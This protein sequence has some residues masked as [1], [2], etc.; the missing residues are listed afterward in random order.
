MHRHLAWR[1]SAGR[2]ALSILIVLTAATG[3]RAQNTFS[4]DFTGTST[5]NSWL[6][7]NGACL[8]AGTATG[9]GTAGSNPGSPPSCVSIAN[10]YYKRDVSALQPRGDLAL[11]GGQN[12]TSGNAQTLP[13]PVGQGALRFT[14]G[15]PYG[16]NENGAIVSSSAFDAGQGVQITFKTVTY[17]G[18]SGG[19]THDGADGIGFYL[20]DATQFPATPTSSPIWNG[21]GGFGGSLGYSCSNTNFPYDGLVAGYIGLGIDEYGNFL[22]AAD[23][24]ATGAASGQ[25][26]QRIGLRG[27]GSISWNWLHANYPGQYPTSQL[28][29]PAPTRPPQV[30]AG[31]TATLAQYAVYKTCS[32]GLLY[33]TTTPVADYSYLPNASA[34][35]PR[36]TLIAGEYAS[37]VYSRPEATP[38]YYNLK[39]TQNGLLSLAYSINGG[40]YNQI[41]T[42]RD[43]TAANAPLPAKLYFGFTG[44]AGAV[45]NIHEILCFKATPADSASTSTTTDQ[46]QTGKVQTG[47]QVYFAFYNPNDWTG[48]MTAY[49]LSVNGSGV[50]SIDPTAVWD[51]QCVLTGVANLPN[52][53]CPTTGL[54]TPAS[55]EPPTTGSGGRVMLTWNGLD[56][57]ANPGSAGIPFEWASI[58]GAE[59]STLDA[60]DAGSPNANRLNY[61][62]GVRTHEV[63]TAGV[64]LFR[65][66]DGI[67][68]DIVD[69]SPVWVGAPSSPYSLA[70]YDRYVSADATPENS[71][72]NSYASFRSNNVSRLN[73]IYVG[74]NDGFLHAFRTGVEDGTGTLLSAPAVNDGQEILAY[75]PGPILDSIRNATTPA[76]DLSDP[77]YAH[78]FSVDAS[79]G[80]GDL[81]YGGAWHTWLVGGLGAGGAGIYALDITDPST[82]SFSESNAAAIVKGDWNSATI[83]CA[84]LG[85]C[86]SHLGNTY[87]TPVIRRLHNGQWAAIFGNGFGS[88]S[89]DAGIYVMTIDQA[90][91]ATTFYYLSTGTGSAASPNGIAYV[92]AADLDGDHITDYVYAG[93]L[94]GNVWRFDL[95]AA[96]PSSWAVRSGA[97]FKTQAGQPITTPLIVATAQLT[98]GAP[99]VLL[100]FGTG[101]RTQITTTTPTTY[102]T[103]TQSL[104]GVWDWDFS[105]WNAHSA[106]IYSSL[107]AAQMAAAAGSA[108]APLTYAKLQAQTFA[109]GATA[110]TVDTSNAT[111]NWAECTTTS[112]ITCGAT[113]FG[114]YVNLPG[115]SGTGSAEQ[116]VSNPILYQQALI[117]NSVIP[118]SNS[119]LSCSSSTDQGI[120][121]VISVTSGGTFTTST[122]TRTSGFLNHTDTA[123]VGLLTNQTGALTILST[124]SGSTYAIGQNLT[125]TSGTSGA[126]PAPPGSAIGLNLPTNT[127]IN[128]VTWTQVR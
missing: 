26:G 109:A 2:A 112:P 94:Q 86:G 104:Y 113:A 20:I 81:F 47:S 115:T 6:Y 70:W 63:N 42:N 98:P 44:S 87:G 19:R 37:G 3:A 72:T 31:T 82:T 74:A 59:Q 120:T 77:Q 111:V 51:S 80:T 11:V 123:M 69:S 89:G 76:L 128:R 92:T 78:K 38:I 56:T 10:S 71:S 103:A 79:P 122:G 39:I 126:L 84:N 40:A 50:V 124:G 100:S 99:S 9:T 46:Q 101:Q 73:V 105:T 32:T 97:L 91:G 65:A 102:S 29:S 53:V 95:T 35:L 22:N 75:M 18:D 36:G 108:T 55:A 27:R 114:W 21:V 30:P 25:Q 13:D 41:I 106:S 33:G 107:S 49:G 61:L 58:T 67:L 28:T 96:T 5:T 4:E 48:R 8:T 66:R 24:T 62:R 93:D 64:G 110:G 17:R 54:A 90:T 15:Y 88:A 57:A 1:R 125:P 127:K 83:S 12:G 52:S 116:I 14:N 117:V 121:Y 68:G 7:Y 16:Y 119:P 34:V 60:G 85:N 45:S 23:N 43:I 118:A